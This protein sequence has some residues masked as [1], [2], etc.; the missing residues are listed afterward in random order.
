MIW[1]SRPFAVAYGRQLQAELKRIAAILE[2][3]VTEKVSCTWVCR[4]VR[5]RAR[6][7]VGRSFK[8]PERSQRL[9]TTVDRA[10]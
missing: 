4:P 3:P 9:P 6:Q 10:A 7:R 5:L 2:Q 1:L 8:R